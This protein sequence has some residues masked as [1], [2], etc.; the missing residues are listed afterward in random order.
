MSSPWSLDDVLSFAAAE[1]SKTA[2]YISQYQSPDEL[3]QL[4][5]QAE[6]SAKGVKPEEALLRPRMPPKVCF[7]Q[8]R[9][10]GSRQKNDRLGKT[11]NATRNVGVTRAAILNDALATWLCGSGLQTSGRDIDLAN[12]IAPSFFSEPGAAA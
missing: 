3:L 7:P 11:H 2:R 10:N 9:R 1:E 5:L 4:Q 6:A 8:Q 12:E